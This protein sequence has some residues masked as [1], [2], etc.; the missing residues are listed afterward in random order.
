MGWPW[1]RRA[2][3]AIE[4]RA[5][6]S[7]FTAEIMAARESY[8]GG[9]RGV[10]ELTATV[11]SCISLW[12][13]GLSIA[14]VDGA[15][16]L[17]PRVLAMIARALALRGDALF[18]I[19]DN[20]LIAASDWDVSTRDGEP[21]AYRL[22]ISEAGGG[23][24]VTALAG[25]VFHVRIGADP[26][27]PWIG[28]APLRRAAL[29]AGLLHALESALCEIFENAPLGSQIV[30]FPESP[31][32][33]NERLSRGFRGRRGAVLLRESVNVTAAGGATPQADWRPNDL[34]P[35][36][37]RT[38]TVQ[39]LAA[40]REAICAVYGVLPSLIAQSTTGPLV[41]EAQRHLAAWVLQPIAEL[42]AEEARSKLGGDVDL[43]VISPLQ[44]F[45]QGG[46]ARAL[47]AYVE[48]IAAAKAANLSVDELSAALKFIDEGTPRLT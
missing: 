5:S 22:T 20:R 41:R 26:V 46:R 15:P 48:A 28:Q 10:G 36:I 14:Q 47:G 7:G 38:Q 13:H 44:A 17:T 27:A 32:T 42:I 23:R 12:E 11:Q 2:A 37:S 1:Q 39:H 24:T 8:V 30:P 43:D 18:F 21:A 31:Q 3:P 6:G 16:M 34:S 9:R 4:K 35:D 25:E 19:G 45:D 33:D 40:A 29:T